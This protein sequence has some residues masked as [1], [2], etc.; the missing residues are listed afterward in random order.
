M[1]NALHERYY[2]IGKERYLVQTWSQKKIEWKET[3][4]SSWYE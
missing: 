3:T 2:N 4:G 1:H